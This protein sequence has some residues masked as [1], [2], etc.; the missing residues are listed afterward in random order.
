M[1]VAYLEIADLEYLD[2]QYERSF[3][4]L[5]N[6]RRLVRRPNAR[7]LWLGVRIEHRRNNKDA[8]DSYGLALEKMF[9]DSKENRPYQQWRLSR[10]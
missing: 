10:S 6:Y 4:Y 1:A 9:P 2:G 8:Q 3:N 7:S 5:S